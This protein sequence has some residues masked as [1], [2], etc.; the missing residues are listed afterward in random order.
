MAA[1]VSAAADAC[2]MGVRETG[3]RGVTPFERR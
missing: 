3:S 1:P 2:A